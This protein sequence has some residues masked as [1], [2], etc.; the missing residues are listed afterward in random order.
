MT[1][2]SSSSYMTRS[3][4]GSGRGRS[5]TGEGSARDYFVSGAQELACLRTAAVE[6]DISASDPGLDLRTAVRRQFE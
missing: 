4:I 6:Q 3:G 1:A 2:R 5:G